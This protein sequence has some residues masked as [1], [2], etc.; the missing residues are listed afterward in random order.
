MKLSIVIISDTHNKHKQIKSEDLPAADVIIHCGDFT[1]MGYGH[2]ISKFMKWFGNLHQYDNKIV[3]A[4]NH[5]FM[6]ENASVLAK[7]H[8]PDNVIYLEDS[9]VEI[10]GINFYGTPVQK[11]FNNWA[12]NRPEEKLKQH[13]EAIP[14]NTDVLITHSPPYGI[15]DFG[16]YSRDEIGSQSLRDEIINRIRPKISAFGHAHTNHGI[17][18][19]NEIKFINASNLNDKYEY[20]Y[21]P[22]IVELEI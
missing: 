17:T 8:V 15:R 10:L 19:I 3:I 16:F 4:G 6:F 2:E 22:I 7:A 13:W 12:F 20:M 9:G 1:S 18:E 21:K 14:D 5:D 11:P